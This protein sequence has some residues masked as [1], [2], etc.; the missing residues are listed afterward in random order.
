MSVWQ[1]P[2][3]SM[4]T[5]ASP[6]PGSVSSTSVTFS[7]A[8]NS[9]STAARIF[10]GSPPRVGGRATLVE[11]PSGRPAALVQRRVPERAAEA[12]QPEAGQRFGA[13]QHPG[14][15][16]MAD[17]GDHAGQQGAPAQASGADAEHDQDL[18]GR[19]TPDGARRVGGGED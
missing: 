15:Q 8:P 17:Q 11:V 12:E 4:R 3:A 10:T 9:S 19:G 14:P 7:G 6:G 5:S 1:I 2:H 18:G 16:A 13:R